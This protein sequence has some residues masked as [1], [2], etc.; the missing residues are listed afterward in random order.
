M[1]SIRHQL[2]VFWLPPAWALLRLARL[3]SAA[4]QTFLREL[5]QKFWTAVHVALVCDRRALNYRSAHRPNQDSLSSP[6]PDTFTRYQHPDSSL[7]R[8]SG[9]RRR[10]NFVMTLPSSAARSLLRS[11]PADRPKWRIIPPFIV[12]KIDKQPLAG[13]PRYPFGIPRTD[14]GNNPWSS[15]SYRAVD[16]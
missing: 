9:T 13:D 5:D 10:A 16:C 15:P 14:N 3:M 7:P 1:D 11:H 6:L 12:S 2:R 4:S 8:H